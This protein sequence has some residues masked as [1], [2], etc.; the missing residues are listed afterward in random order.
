MA[1]AYCANEPQSR[2]TTK[3]SAMGGPQK[4]RPK[5]ESWKTAVSDLMFDTAVRRFAFLQRPGETCSQFAKRWGM[6]LESAMGFLCGG[7]ISYDDF[8]RM[9]KHSDGIRQW[10]SMGR[11]SRV[12]PD[13]RA[14]FEAMRGKNGMDAAKQDCR[15]CL[16]WVQGMAELIQVKRASG[17]GVESDEATLSHLL[18]KLRAYQHVWVMPED[19][20]DQCESYTGTKFDSQIE[21]VA[22]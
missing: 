3:V 16:T 18:G 14:R 5:R 10:I 15:Y 17:T 19:I 4:T 21:T 12:P 6:S 7:E 9:N 2:K 20:R 13:D 11:I 22:R 1:K 8:S